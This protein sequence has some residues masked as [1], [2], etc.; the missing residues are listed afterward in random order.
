MKLG[1]GAFMPISPVFMYLHQCQQSLI[2][3]EKLQFYDLY[4][5]HKSPLKTMPFHAILVE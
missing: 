3:Q 4:R 2:S 1:I 5:L